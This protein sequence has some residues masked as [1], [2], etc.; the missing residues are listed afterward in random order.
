VPNLRLSK[1]DR[2]RLGCPELL[3]V[4]VTSI[5]NREAIA[6][7]KLGYATPTVFRRALSVR[8]LDEGAFDVDPLAWTGV[9]WLALKRRGIDADL[10]D[11]EFDLDALEYVADPEL[12]DPVEVDEAGKEPEPEGSTNSES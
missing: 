4:D 8:K 10:L 12:P 6:L 2:D 7:R 1:P 11:L 3:P 5:T 9:V